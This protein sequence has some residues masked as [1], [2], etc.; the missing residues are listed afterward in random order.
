MNKG[1]ADL[2]ELVLRCHDVESREIISEAIASYHVGALRAAIVTTWLAVYF[3]IASKIRS[4]AIGGSTAAQGWVAD[5]D[6]YSNQY[7]PEQ[8]D[9]ASPLLQIEKS[10]LNKAASTD[11]ELISKVE[12][13]DLRRLRTDRNRCAHPSMQNAEERFQPSAELVRTH[14]R[15]AITFVLSR[16]PIQGR[17]AVDRYLSICSDP[18]FPQVS[19]D[20]VEVL[21]SSRADGISAPN[22]STIL[23]SLLNDIFDEAT[24]AVERKQRHAAIE[25][26]RELFQASFPESFVAPLSNQIQHF[27]A[28]RWSIFFALLRFAPWIWDYLDMLAK[29]NS[30]LAVETAD[31]DEVADRRPVLEALR[32]EH[33]KEHAIRRLSD[34]SIAQL[35]TSRPAISPTTK[36]D[37]GLRRLGDS[38]SFDE[39]RRIIRNLVSPNVDLLD[40]DRLDRL[41]T[42]YVE[43]FQVTQATVATN[44]LHRILAE[45]PL[46]SLGPVAGWRAVQE[47]KSR[48]HNSE[49]IELISKIEEVFEEV[50]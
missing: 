23:S 10:I 9:T 16:P 18:G 43:N 32:V 5:L 50:Q 12:L 34:F 19:I 49:D 28:R 14:L 40:T 15:N 29:N 3:D 31:M 33:L 8:P 22:L 39:T 17:L 2:D 41:L 25:A 36:L 1:L 7:D 4:L 26:T 13:S 38:G 45:L 46:E 47:V 21:K 42:V 11:F 35:K 48:S 27:E 30:I 6:R 24:T 37:E 44:F 20:A